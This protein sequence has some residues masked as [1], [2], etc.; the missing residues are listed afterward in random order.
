MLP[1]CPPA[2]SP[3]FSLFS[4]PL[5]P[6][7]ALDLGEGL[8]QASLFA[9]HPCLRCQE[10]PRYTLPRHLFWFSDRCL[11]LGREGAHAGFP[12]A[13]VWRDGHPLLQPRPR[14]CPTPALTQVQMFTGS[15]L[16]TLPSAT[17]RP[18]RKSTRS[19]RHH[20]SWRHSPPAHSR[21]LKKKNRK[22][23]KGKE[24][25]KENC[26]PRKLFRESI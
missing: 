13:C 17:R 16:P 7:S 11:V 12:K 19:M 5:S 10:W 3:I 14:L 2:A 6:P 15:L 4:A 18:Q 23:E 26:K 9:A 21:S 24:K 22:K 1:A 8:P 20:H 25:K